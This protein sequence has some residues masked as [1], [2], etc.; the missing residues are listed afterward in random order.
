MT[1]VAFNGSARLDGNTAILLKGAL[2]ALE[3]EGIQTVQRLGQNM[4]WALKTLKA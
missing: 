3:R 1:V 4:A 2:A